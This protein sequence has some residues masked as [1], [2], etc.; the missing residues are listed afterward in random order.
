MRRLAVLALLAGCAAEPDPVLDLEGASHRWA[1]GSKVS[2]R[3][4]WSDD[5]VLG[6]MGVN[7]ERFDLLGPGEVTGSSRE[8]LLRASEPGV[9]VVHVER[10]GVELARFEIE[11]AEATDFVVIPRDLTDGAPGY[12][13][14]E[15]LRVLERADVEF[16]LVPVDADFA[17]LDGTGLLEVEPEIGPAGVY[18]R[19]GTNILRVTGWGVGATQV[20]VTAAGTPFGTLEIVTVPASEVAET[21]LDVPSEDG[22][23]NRDRI[24]LQV[25]GSDASGNRVWGVPAD[26]WR[27]DGTLLSSSSPRYCYRFDPD[28][29]RSS[30]VIAEVGGETFTA[31]IRRGPDW[32]SGDE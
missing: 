27:V 1:V 7:V 24:C 14:P 22:H 28:A 29:E 15:T 8:I 9:G 16:V 6:P 30:M 13:L 17:S 10:D 3:L 11:A 20:P 19:E 21:G 25:R 31:S 32:V 23:E 12:R 5:R 2:V 4:H 26:A 18:L